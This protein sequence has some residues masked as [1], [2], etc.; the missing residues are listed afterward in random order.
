MRIKIIGWILLV[1]VLMSACAQHKAVPLIEDRSAIEEKVAGPL[2]ADTNPVRCD[3]PLGQ[4][5]YLS[6]LRG[7][8]GRPPQFH[9]VGSFAPGPYGNI[10]DGYSVTSGTNTVM[11]FMDMYHPGFIETN[12]VPGFTIVGK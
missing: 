1:C 10:L 11:I 7:P 6:R 9:R 4:R 5:A 12:A 8:D 3:M 2:G